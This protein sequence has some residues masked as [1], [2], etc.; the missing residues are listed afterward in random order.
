MLP[1]ASEGGCYCIDQTAQDLLVGPG[2]SAKEQTRNKFRLSQPE[3]LARD[4]DVVKNPSL[5]FRVGISMRGNVG[6]L[7]GDCHLTICRLS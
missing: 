1:P 7:F 3:A 4:R 2:F 5:T 6:K